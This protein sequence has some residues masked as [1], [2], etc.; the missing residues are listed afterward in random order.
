VA[1]VMCYVG[2]HGHPRL[3]LT[4]LLSAG[5]CAVGRTRRK[6]LEGRW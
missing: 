1:L 6:I 3:V 5:R 2:C 4:G